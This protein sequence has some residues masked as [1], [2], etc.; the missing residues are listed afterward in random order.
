MNLILFGP[1]SAGKGSQAKKIVEDYNLRHISTGD[2]F[3]HNI[4]MKTEI[5]LEAKKYMDRGDLVPD[6]V[7]IE[8]VRG[9]LEEGFILDGFPRTVKQ[10][11][12][13]D[14]IIKEKG[15]SQ[16]SVIRLVVDDEQLIDRVTGRRKIGRAHV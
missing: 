5:G 3:R 14:E 10:A 8:M 9:A 2:I 16:P 15:L 11:I 7:T 4:S 6:E 1:P 12:A 13:L